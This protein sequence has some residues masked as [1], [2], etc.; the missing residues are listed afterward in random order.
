MNVNK[1][2]AFMIAA[3]MMV[4]TL[5]SMSWGSAEAD[6]SR[7]YY[8][9]YN[10]LTESYTEYYLD[11]LFPEEV[12]S[13]YGVIGDEVDFVPCYDTA[14]VHLSCGGSGFIIG[15]NT[16]ATAAH[17]LIN[18]NGLVEN[19]VNIV[20]QDGT[21]IDDF[22]PVEYHIPETYATSFSLSY[23][24]ALIVLDSDVNL[25]TYGAFKLGVPLD[26]FMT[27]GSDV[28]VAGF[29]Q[30][31]DDV[32][33]EVENYQYGRR[34]QAT[35]GILYKNFSDKDRRFYYSADNAGGTSGGPV[36]ISETTSD[37]NEYKVA[38]GINTYE[39]WRTVNNVKIYTYNSG[40][41][42]TPAL[43]KFYKNNYKAKIE[44]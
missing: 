19:T 43:L 22:T 10:C 37:E 41:R 28:T 34:F 29:P 12:V 30:L 18:S 4:G 38:L 20:D 6:S 13:T 8:R 16:I 44:E 31:S 2:F 23:D 5:S 42:F 26:S 24:Y 25:L 11:E 36:Y 39:H 35:G 15:K 27:S 40:V 9:E 32:A 14:V 17:C 33:E 21:L 7:R 1:K 3:T